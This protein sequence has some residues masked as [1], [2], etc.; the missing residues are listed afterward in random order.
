[1]A[2]MTNSTE[3]ESDLEQLK[4]AKLTKAEKRRL[5]S[6]AQRG[7]TINF[8]YSFADLE[9]YDI[10]D[11]DMMVKSEHEER[12]QS[13][14]A[15]NQT[16]DHLLHFLAKGRTYLI[17]SVDQDR[18]GIIDGKTNGLEMLDYLEFTAHGP[19]QSIERYSAFIMVVFPNVV[20]F[21]PFDTKQP[22]ESTQKIALKEGIVRVE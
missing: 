4:K 6:E 13:A 10:L 17:F 19:I 7:L 20:E 18:I 16:F 8:E 22:V 14:P 9:E 3:P 2:N 15:T 11:I 21:I 1:M 5:L 12:T